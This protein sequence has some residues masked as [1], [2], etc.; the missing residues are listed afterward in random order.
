MRGCA[1]RS[2]PTS[3]GS[4]GPRRCSCGWSP[5]R[6]ACSRCP[7]S[8]RRKPGSP[9]AEAPSRLNH[10]IA[11]WPFHGRSRSIGCVLSTPARALAARG[12]RQGLVPGPGVARGMETRIAFVRLALRDDRLRLDAQP[13]VDLHT[14]A[15]VAEELLL[16]FVRRDGSIDLPGPYV[17][18]AE[19]YRLAVELDEWV[20]NRAAELAAT[21]RRLHVNLSGRTLAECSFADRV[22]AAMARHGVDA[23]LL[24]FEITETAPA[25]DLPSAYE[26]AERITG[27]GAG[28]AL[29]DFG[30]GYGSLSYLRRLPVTMVKIDREFVA[31]I[32][33]DDRSRALVES[34]VHLAR[35]LRKQTVAEGVEDEATVVAL[36]EC[37]VDFA[38]GFHIARPMPVL[39]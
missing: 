11:V 32:A 28:L 30:T 35:R 9:P 6:R 17:E 18:A 7:T 22:E 3:T 33:V 12:H 21:G 25:L 34:I 14:G 5:A 24:T 38:Q 16:R 19:C 36:R 1:R 23:S 10:P 2:S 31:D 8:S 29:D 20:L 39:L 37:G 4:P 15:T 26:V 27:L 13:I